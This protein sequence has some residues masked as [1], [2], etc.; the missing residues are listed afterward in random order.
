[1]LYAL[2][3]PTL[4]PTA[5]KGDPQDALSAASPIEGAGTP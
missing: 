5:L 4:N 2:P 1:M 3:W